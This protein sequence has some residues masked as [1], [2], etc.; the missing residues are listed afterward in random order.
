MYIPIISCFAKHL[1]QEKTPTAF[2]TNFVDGINFTQADVNRHYNLSPPYASWSLC[3][4]VFPFMEWPYFKGGTWGWRINKDLCFHNASLSA[5]HKT[6]LPMVIY[7]QCRHVP[8]FGVKVGSSGR[9]SIYDVMG[10]SSSSFQ[11]INLWFYDKP[12]EA[13]VQAR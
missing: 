8:Q 3:L 10:W 7:P 12:Q 9:A 11:F 1:M 4:L 6:S 5:K 2:S 13:L